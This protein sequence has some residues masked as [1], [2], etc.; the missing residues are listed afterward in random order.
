[1]IG[2]VSDANS[3]FTD[4]GQIVIGFLPGAFDATGKTQ[5][6]VDITPVS[7]CPK[8]PDIQFVTNVYQITADAPLVRSAN[9]VLRYSNLVPAPSCHL[10]GARPERPV[11]SRSAGNEASRSRSRRQESA[12]LLRGRL[13][14]ER[15]DRQVIRCQSAAAD[16]GG[17]AHRRCA[18]RRHSAGDAAPAVSAA[19]VDEED[20]D[21]EPE[22]TRRT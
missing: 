12:R 10:R 16:R 13:P 11:D 21:E 7:P 22:T 8:P 20:D 17:G 18:A 14:R 19:E 2:G 15:D 1:M 4:D 3:A 9:L 5:I 6:S